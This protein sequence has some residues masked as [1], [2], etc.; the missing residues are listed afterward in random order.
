MEGHLVPPSMG[1]ELAVRQ[2]TNTPWWW[3]LATLIKVRAVLAPGPARGG[4][5][6]KAS[7][8]R[9]RPAREQLG[10]RHPQTWEPPQRGKAKNRP[11]EARSCFDKPTNQKTVGQYRTTHNYRDPAFLGAR[12]GDKLF[13][14]LLIMTLWFGIGGQGFWGFAGWLWLE[15]PNPEPSP[16][17]HGSNA[18]TACGCV[19]RRMPACCEHR[20]LGASTSGC[21]ILTNRQQVHSGQL[22]K[23]GRRPVHMVGACFWFDRL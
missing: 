11:G 1:A 18:H 15:P 4:R 21:F 5:G 20:S 9:N 2:A 3:G 10:V 16:A 19:A 14:G 17:T 13:T 12:L 6:G 7:A 8:L 23:R 22:H